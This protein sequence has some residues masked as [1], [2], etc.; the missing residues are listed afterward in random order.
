MAIGCICWNHYLNY[1]SSIDVL[2]N[3]WG[4]PSSDTRDEIYPVSQN[5]TYMNRNYMVLFTK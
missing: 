1:S 2:F 5:I 3:G 4:H